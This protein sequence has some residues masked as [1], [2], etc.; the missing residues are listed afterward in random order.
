MPPKLLGNYPLTHTSFEKLETCFQ[1]FCTPSFRKLNTREKFKKINKALL[2][3]IQETPTPCFLLGQTIE[4]IARVNTDAILAT[5]YKM[6][7]FEFWLNNF[8]QLSPDDQYLVRAKIAGKFLPRQEYSAFFPIGSGK[9]YSG[10]HFIAAHIAPD[11]DTT[12]ASF[13]GWVDAFAAKV[14]SAT[15]KWN[16]PQAVQNSHIKIL[17]ESLFSKK[18]F[19][20][21]ARSASS[22]TLSALD[23]ISQK[24]V[25]KLVKHK[26]S[27]EID[28]SFLGK[29]ILIV[30]DN[31]HYMGCLHPNEL[32]STRQIVLLFSQTMRWLQSTV[33]ETIITLLAQKKVTKADIEEALD[34]LFK[35]PIKKSAPIVEAT[36]KQRRFQH[37]LFKRIFSIPKGFEASFL[38]FI[39]SQNMLH[40]LHQS[41][42][43][44]DFFDK[45]NALI[46]ER[47]TI[48]SCIKT[49]FSVLDS[50]SLNVKNHVDT[51]NFLLEVKEKVLQIP[52]VFL[53][54]KSEVD[55]MRSK[56][57]H[58]EYL[59]VIVTQEDGSH[60]C[61]GVVYASDLKRQLLGTVSLRDF[62]NEQETKIASY[63]EIISIID[64]HKSNIQTT[65]AATIVSSDAQSANTLVAE[66]ALHINERYSTL[67]QTQKAIDSQLKQRSD[68]KKLQRLLQYS[69]NCKNKMF[70][71][72]PD[73]EFAEY[74]CFLYAILDDT[75]LL[76]KVSFRDVLVIQKLVNRMKT[77]VV[78]A[79]FE[80][81]SFDTLSRDA[82]FAKNAACVILQ[83][84]DMYSIYK[85]IFSHKEKEV[86]TNIQKCISS[87][88]LE[89]FSDTKEQNGCARVGQVKLFQSNISYFQKHIETLRSIWYES[90]KKIYEAR[91]HMDL[92]ML[93]LSTIASADEV[94]EGNPSKW[95]HKDEIW[96]WTPETQQGN[97][98]LV[99]FLTSFQGC[100]AVQKNTF[101]VCFLGPNCTE[102]ESLFSQNFAK[103]RQ[104]RASNYKEGLPLSVLRFQAGLINSRKALITPYLPR[105]IS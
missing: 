54:L 8:S 15:H 7:D 61:V 46:E 71:I 13:W 30:D 6:E 97:F 53:T 73:R 49:L 40:G 104:T 48:F 36:E 88:S 21:A 17:F 29:P 24:S 81:I 10:A 32:E 65:S 85:N 22:L 95:S 94:Y 12:V 64:H 96:I 45:S 27:T 98:R 69:I 67:G 19:D 16:L 89:L 28:H 66:L 18:V 62:S 82:N 23:L 43:T 76:A 5:P 41:L 31:D 47:T 34:T 91:P 42:Q 58:F 79:D 90:A 37:E 9:T 103:A 100:D 68:T 39:Q 11:A 99:S 70:Y 25:I 26:K 59:P 93:M 105:F 72:H 101:Q 56:I 51:L 86:D 75:D 57:A 63:L 92:H 1:A 14:A 50:A 60:V 52:N 83:N 55:E 3:L 87:E 35:M 80:S 38:E 84:E 78:G 102:L 33:Q 20:I 2:K 77:L 44:L 74:L 4:F